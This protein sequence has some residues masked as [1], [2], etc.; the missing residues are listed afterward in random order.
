MAAQSAGPSAGQHTDIN[1]R[2]RFLQLDATA[3]AALKRMKPLI[4]QALPGALDAFYGHVKQFGHASSFFRDQGHMDHAKGH[5]MR[6]WMTIAS[7]DFGP[8]Y[9]ESVRKIGLAHARIGLEPRWYL[10][11]YAHLVATMVRALIEQ[12]MP[13]G[14]LANNKAINQALDDVAVFQRAAMLD[15]DFAISIYLEESEASKKRMME[16]LAASFENRIKGVVDGVAAAATEL[17][18]TARSMSDIASRTSDQATVVAAASE[19]ATANVSVV[20]ASADQMSQSVREIASRM[21]EAAA[22]TSNAVAMA[23]A[24]AQTIN[25]LSVAASKIGAVVSMISDIAAQTNLLALNATIESARAGEAGKG[26][27]VVAS[28]VKGLASQTARATEDI[29]QQI[30]AMQAATEQAVNAITTIR[31]AIGDV[32]SS[33]LAINAAV[34]QQAAATEEITRNTREA[35]IGT[36]EVSST[37]V[38]VQEGANTTGGASSQV[39]AAAEELGQQSEEL[40]AAVARFLGE[41]RAA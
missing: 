19:E 28:E 39:V 12:A 35:A 13:K 36:Q 6:H 40:R 17:S 25:E 7:G 26:F 4:E 41:M 24:S 21:G 31:A 18:A 1:E 16:E 15:M 34:E 10:G 9:V 32:S 33:A 30:D 37:I 27:A 3:S 8:A 5:Q 23:D 38:Q 22:T 29:K 20:A 14:P 2:L 11:G